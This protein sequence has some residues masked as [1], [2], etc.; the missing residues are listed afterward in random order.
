MYHGT[1][2]A[3]GVN[4]LPAAGD[5]CLLMRH[6]AAL[7]VS[8]TQIGKTNKTSGLQ[9]NVRKAERWSFIHSFILNIYIAPLQQNYSEVTEKSTDISF[10]GEP[11]EQQINFVNY[12]RL[13]ST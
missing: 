5:T 9:I 12:G 13:I 11:I 3:N 1:V 7:I 4:N 2:S 10:M 8:M 6:G